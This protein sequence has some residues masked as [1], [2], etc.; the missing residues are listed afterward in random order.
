MNKHLVGSRT[1]SVESADQSA[2]T[3]PS[4][5]DR[6]QSEEF[7]RAYE[8]LPEYDVAES[9]VRL[10]HLRELT[11]KD[12]ARRMHTWQPAVARIE[13]AGANVRLSTL[14]TLADA[15]NARVRIRLEP[16][17]YRFPHTPPWWECIDF[18]MA[19]SVEQAN[20]TLTFQGSAKDLIAAHLNVE[21]GPY[22]PDNWVKHGALTQKRVPATAGATADHA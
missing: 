6:V 20:F 19:T 16:A 22:H 13:A 2:S 8:S 21:F 4:L 5:G 17:E 12:L 18:G 15:L 9:V 1:L 11:Q 3:S 7:R 14:K 10:R